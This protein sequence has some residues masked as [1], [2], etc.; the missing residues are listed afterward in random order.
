MKMYWFRYLARFVLFSRLNMVLLIMSDTHEVVQGG[1]S[2]AAVPPATIG[3]VLSYVAI[4][5]NEHMQ[6]SF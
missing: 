1:R 3:L 2:Y 5:H 6:A 4:H